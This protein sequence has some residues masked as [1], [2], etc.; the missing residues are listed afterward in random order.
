MRR[1][2]L[3]V[4]FLG[5][6]LIHAQTPTEDS[7]DNIRLAQLINLSEVVVSSNLNISRFIEQVKKD[8]TFY[9]AFKNLRVLGFTSSNDILLRDKKGTPSARL[10]SKT[11]QVREAGCRTM[12]VLEE[13]AQGDFYDRDGGYNYY[14]AELYAGL[15]FTKGK[16][17]GETN[18]L[19]SSK[20]NPRE[21]RGLAKHKEQL[22]MLLFNPGQK[23]PGIPLIGDKIDLF[24]PQRAQLYDFYIDYADRNGE[25]C[26]LFSIKTKEN[27]RSGALDKIV[28]D[29]MD[30]WFSIKTMEVL[31]RHYTMSYD[32]GVYDFHV[33]MEAE[34]TRFNG[35]V[36][37]KVLRYVGNWD[38]AFKKR[39]R[40]V[41]TATIYDFKQ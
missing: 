5:S 28:V 20:L 18:V 36:V 34:M 21:Q 35:M 3:T 33:Q 30:T 19:R 9:K 12:Q 41:F 37:P 6:S 17:C 29:K 24:D 16:V 38:V 40:G 13:N 14:T 27:L 22:K 32:A 15:F 39:E 23:V 31:A 7:L 26:Y 11:R 2:L 1:Y 8:T 4:L 10:I 25:S